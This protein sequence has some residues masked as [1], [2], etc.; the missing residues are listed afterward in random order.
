MHLDL[1]TKSSSGVHLSP[2]GINGADN[3][4][5]EDGGEDDREVVVW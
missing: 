4:V 5:D 1:Y 3:F 2:F